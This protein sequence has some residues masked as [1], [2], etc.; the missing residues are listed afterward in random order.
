MYWAG[1]SIELA[2]GHPVPKP[3]ETLQRGEGVAIVLTGPAVRAWRE[4]G[5]IWKVWSPCLILAQL[6]TGKREHDILHILSCYAPTEAATRG[7]K[8]SFYDDSMIRL[9]QSFHEGMKVQVSI[10]GELLE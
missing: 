8:D 1:K 5:E 10:N 6:R 2:A 4:A 3:G 9:V 7:E